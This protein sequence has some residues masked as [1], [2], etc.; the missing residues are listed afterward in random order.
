MA[1]AGGRMPSH[2][3]LDIDLLSYCKR[4]ERRTV[5][6]C[7]RATEACGVPVTVDLE[8]DADFWIRI[9]KRLAVARVLGSVLEDTV[10]R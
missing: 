2:E 10:Y 4:I 6:S 3:P 9:I 7:S 5:T 8:P 1:R